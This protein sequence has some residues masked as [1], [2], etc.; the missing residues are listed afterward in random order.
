MGQSSGSIHHHAQWSIHHYAQTSERQA[1]SRSTRCKTVTSGRRSS[2]CGQS[3][4][5]SQGK[6]VGRKMRAC[7]RGWGSRAGGQMDGRE[8]GEE[9]WERRQNREGEEGGRK[10][11]SIMLRS[12]QPTVGDT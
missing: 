3:K 2:G 5:G 9:G 7:E 1:K 4:Q 6:G 11:L 8:E 12:L 10:A